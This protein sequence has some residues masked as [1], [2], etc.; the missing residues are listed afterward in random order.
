M[1]TAKS[2]K[3]KAT[4]PAR[5]RSA[6]ST[7]R[8]RISVRGVVQGVGFRPF[9]YSL[10]KKLRLT[11]WVLNSP[12]GVQIEAEGPQSGLED[13]LVRLQKEKPRHAFIQSLEWS[14]LDPVGFKGFEIRESKTGG[15][16]V[17]FILPDI[18]TCDLCLEEMSNTR[19]RRHN[20]P[21]INCTLCGP[22]FSIIE[23][24]PYDRPNTSMK[25]FKMCP[26]CAKEYGDPEDRRFHAQPTACPVCGPMIQLLDD[27]GA[28]VASDAVAL[29]EACEVVSEGKVLG[30]KG[31][32]GFLLIADARN[33]AVLRRLR[34]RKLREEKPLAL[35]YP[36]EESVGTDCELDVLETRLL[37]SP[38]KP[39][40]LL[41]KKAKCSISEFVAPG[42]PYLG[43]M[44][45]YA[46]LHHL[47]MSRLGYPV[48]ATSGNLTDEPMAIETDEALEKLGGIADAFLTHDRPIVRRMDDS[49]SRVLDGREVLYSGGR[50]ATRPCPS[51]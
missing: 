26:K 16:K 5:V 50:E 10:A 21:F 1:P 19:D 23:K 44:L 43:V 41:R 14:Y 18:S 39:I 20:Y 3:T 11:G 8:I 32:G 51:R 4:S 48:V 29:D 7:R 24:L 34:E 17:A 30:L 12:Q 46:P 2:K 9:V 35:M 38:E 33:D 27:G 13:F 31:I 6:S 25:S 45:P 49:I 36:D 22:R 28:M 47:L 37:T 40:V 15:E 42:N